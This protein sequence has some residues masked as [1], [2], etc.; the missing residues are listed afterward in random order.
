MGGL[1]A[2]L[3]AVAAAL[4]VLGAGAAWSAEPIKIRVG[5]VVVPANLP[6]ILFAKE[7]VAKHLGQ[8]YAMD[9]IHF[10]GTPLMI[11]AMASGELD[12]GLLAYSSFALAVENAGL[13]DLRVIADDFQDGVEGYYTNEYMVRKDSPIRTVEDLKGKTLATNA[14]GSAVDVALRVM[15]R[16]HGLD[17]KKDLNIIEVAFP[18]MK[19]VLADQK[20]DLISGVVPFSVDPGLRETARTLFTQKEAVGTTQMIVWAARASFLEKNRAAM[21]DFMEDEL[22][23]LRFYRDPA[24]HAAVVDIVA[25]YTK[26]PRERF[27]SWVFTKSGDYYRDPDGLPNLDALQANIDTQRELGLL[28]APLEIG[29]Y[30]D[31]SIVKDAGQRLK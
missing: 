4:L 19:A 2:A 16:K 29:K 21:V 18:N 11:T 27:D 10:N 6:P 8:T 17:D 26:Q 5:W 25:Q 23:A 13:K 31:L 22:R 12:I 9:P 7:G 1:R 20:V 15:L 28:K 14:A 24:N 30:A 3:G